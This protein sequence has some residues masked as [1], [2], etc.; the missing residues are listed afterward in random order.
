MEYKTVESV[1]AASRTLKALSDLGYNMSSAVA[2][3][4]DNSISKGKANNIWFYFDSDDENKFR[5]RI[6]DDGIGMTKDELEEAMRLGSS[7]ENYESGDLSKYGMG[8]KTASLSQAEELTVISMHSK[9]KPTGFKWDMH[10]IKKENKWE[11]FSYD[12]NN[13]KELKSKLDLNRV[14]KKHLSVSDSWTV[15]CWDDLKKFQKDFD[16]YQSSVTAENFYHRKFDSL[17]KYTRLVFHRFLK[18]DNRVKNVNIYFN[19]IKIEPLNPFC[20]DEKNTIEYVL[21]DA[22]ANYSLDQ[23]IPP[24]KISAYIL[25][26]NPKK[27]GEFNFSSIEAWEEAK[28]V[29]SWNDAQ[30]YYVYRNDRLIN[31]GG[32]FYTK[33]KDE[34][35]KLARASIDLTDEHDELFTLDIKKT[36]VQFPETLKIHLKDKVNK[37][38]IKAAKKR[39]SGTN[40]KTEQPMNS[41]RSKRSKNK[42]S[43]FSKSLVDID[44]IG[45]RHNNNQQELV[46]SNPFGGKITDDLTY[47]MLEAGQKIISDSFGEDTYLWKMV[48]NPDNEFQVLVNTDHPFYDLV[49]NSEKNKK[50]TAVMDAFLFAMSFIELKCIS[51]ENE[52]LF[53]QMREVGSQVLKRFVEE[54][55]LTE[56][57]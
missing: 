45:V 21:K 6:I 26:T 39:Y 10:H 14:F 18:P 27:P 47:Q 57:I 28:G 46:I 25:P 22:V 13:I 15:V 35:D 53:N 32:W 31:F 11:I 12:E 42:I 4:I 56:K 52:H 20:L 23:N 24:V 48:P 34:H 8:M 50:T 7:D 54:N 55:I 43:T 16:S 3:I 41:I 9:Q 5:I 17:E 1:P 44:N 33:G 36:R 30:G 40:K 19:N 37:G 51:D 29:L 2:D 38:F 49:Y